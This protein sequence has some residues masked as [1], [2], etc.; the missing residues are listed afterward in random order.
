MLDLDAP[1]RGP[2]KKRR[3]VSQRRKDQRRAS[4]RRHAL[5]ALPLDVGGFAWFVSR[6]QRE[7]AEAQAW[8]DARRAFALLGVGQ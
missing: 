2:A 6:R 1:S 5:G 3:T 8:A 4:F 7:A